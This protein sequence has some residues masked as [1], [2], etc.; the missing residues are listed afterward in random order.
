MNQFLAEFEL[1]VM[2]AVKAL[3]EEAYGAA[4][5]REIEARTN[6]PVTLGAIYA[7]LKR[8][9]DKGYLRFES[10]GPRPM[11][12]GR[13]RKYCRLTD[14]GRHSIDRSVDGFRRMISGI[15]VEGQ[16]G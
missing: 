14:E 7:T 9:G 4:I 8:L 15:P 12:G 3:G 13:S 1:Y 2:L 6:R 11:P 5:L 10:S 16:T